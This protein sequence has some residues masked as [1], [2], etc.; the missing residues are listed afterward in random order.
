MV[1]RPMAAGLELTSKVVFE[2][3]NEFSPVQF[4]KSPETLE[5]TYTNE[6]SDF[7]TIGD[8]RIHYRDEGPEDASVVLLLH[9]SYSSLH[10]WDNWV[11]ELDDE[12]RLVRLD[13]PGFGLTG[14]RS[15]GTHTLSYLVETVGEFCDELGLTD[16]AVAGSSLGGGVAWRLTVER[17]AL[18]SRLILIN[19]GGATLLSQLA[20]NITTI[21]NDLLP[22]YAT[23][24]MMIRILLYDAYAD[25]SKVTREL[26]NRYY[27]LLLRTGN[28]RAV[29]EIAEQ[30]IDHYDGDVSEF[31]L[32][33]PRLPSQHTP[34]PKIWDEYDIAD[35]DVRTLFQWGTEDEWLPLSFGRQLASQVPNAEFIRYEG[36]GHLPMEEHP[37]VTATDATAFL[38]E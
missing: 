32:I 21:G 11:S 13:M 10:T 31:E 5:E 25:N 4:D 26:V 20:R 29:L 6:H 9:G 14:P 37:T 16:V 34:H 35:V 22:R 33:F 24:R 17:P 12:F 2:T 8:S 36:I 15:Q 1:L 23:P 7:V 19:A 30:Y 27:D 38:E 28:R 3:Y 18:V